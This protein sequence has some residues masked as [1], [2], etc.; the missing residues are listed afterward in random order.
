[1]SFLQQYDAA[2]AD[3]KAKL[4]FYWVQTNPQALF[5][6]LRANRP[7]LVTPPPGPVLLTLFADV[8]EV[9][10]RN[11]TF[12]V[13][14]Y[15]PKMDPAVGPYMLA[16]DDTVYNQRDKSVMRALLRQD[17]MPAVAAMA[18]RRAA[19]A[20][21]EVAR[22]GRIEVVSQL[23]RRVPIE[24]VG[25]HFGFPG[26]D[27]ATMMRWSKATQHDMFHNLTNDPKVHQDSV[28][29]GAEMR[30]YLGRLIPA[31]RQAL[32]QVPADDTL[33]RMLL[34]HFPEVI[35]FDDERI[36]SNTMG[37][38]V[39]AV[40]TTSAAVVQLLDQLLDRPDVLAK[41]VA[42]AKANDD[43][44]VA[45]YCWE[46]LRFNPI[47]PFIVRLGVADYT[48]AAGTPRATT[49]KAGTLVLASNAS[50]MM[51][52]AQVPDPEAFTPGRP[53]YHYMHF[54]YGAHTCLGDQ[55]SLAQVSQMVKALLLKPGL[56]RAPGSDGRPDFQDGP[57][58]E[59]FVLQ[60][61]A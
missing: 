29:A 56:K 18:A 9:L 44:T 15:A 61:D 20:V 43:A 17:D 35:G 7:I 31:R 51:D 24:V 27:L 30:A 59:R 22:S 10:S 34:T 52:A 40:E 53:D 4:L 36:V 49:I 5:A 19:E 8:Q 26:P 42:A 1:M 38:L 55:V 12:T 39:G 28:Q 58:P 45:A 16:R 11:A 47:N 21:G 2:P 33:S 41:A 46:A 6:E 57:F 14:P 23:S 3:Q 54:G 37:L 60:F 25:E 50:A 48:V 32:A 13:R